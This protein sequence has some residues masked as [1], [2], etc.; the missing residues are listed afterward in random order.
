MEI[1]IY[2]FLKAVD[3]SNRATIMALKNAVSILEELRELNEEG[4]T[5]VIDT[6]MNLTS[7]EREKVR[8]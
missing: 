4:R 3:E 7:E 8:Q 1:S 5:V 2:D 6:V